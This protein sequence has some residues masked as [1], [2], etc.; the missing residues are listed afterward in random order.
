VAGK[1]DGVN[2]RVVWDLYDAT[3]PVT[4]A[5]SKARTTG[6]PCAIVARLLADGG[7]TRPG[8]DPPEVLGRD[9]ALT[10]WILGELKERGVSIERHE[11]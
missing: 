9:E 10:A 3:D 2:T 5:T 6:F 1:Q 11:I 4:R 8:V 7:F